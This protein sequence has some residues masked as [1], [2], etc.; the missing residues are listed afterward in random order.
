LRNPLNAENFQRHVRP[1]TELPDV[2]CVRGNGRDPLRT[3]RRAAGDRRLS[4]VLRN[5]ISGAKFCSHCGAKID[6]E[7]VPPDARQLCPR[8]Q[9]N[10]DAVVIGN[11]NLRECPRCEGIWADTPSL[12][13][14]C[15]DR[16][17]QA[18]VLGVA[19]LL[20]TDLMATSKGT[21][22]T[23]RVRGAAN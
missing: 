10:M 22:V 1:N 21:F 18:A 3:L 20:P 4:I 17:K 8:C 16:E 19:A 13:Q 15:A 9:V 11:T 23:C 2:R 6:R 12:Q 7:E 14:I 5:D